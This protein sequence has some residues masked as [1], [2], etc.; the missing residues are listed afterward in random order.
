MVVG[1]NVGWCVGK[2]VAGMGNEVGCNGN[3]VASGG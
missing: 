2:Y 3:V 1:N